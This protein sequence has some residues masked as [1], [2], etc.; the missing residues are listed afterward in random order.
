MPISTQQ[1][2]DVLNDVGKRVTVSCKTDHT[3]TARQD[4]LQG[5]D[6]DITICKLAEQLLSDRGA[7]LSFTNNPEHKG[8]TIWTHLSEEDS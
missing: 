4:C 3:H 1:I 5:D 7:R 2:C 8:P 6:R